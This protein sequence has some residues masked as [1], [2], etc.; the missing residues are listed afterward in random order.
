[1]PFA[2]PHARAARREAIVAFRRKSST[3][4]GMDVAVRGDATCSSREDIG[5][6]DWWGDLDNALLDCLAESGGLS[7]AEAGRRLGISEDA[8]VS[9]AAMLA[10]EGRLRIAL[11]EGVGHSGRRVDEEALRA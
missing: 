2:L 4:L 5:M 8:V 11:M 9:V 3:A 1:M 6:D 10:R 7:A